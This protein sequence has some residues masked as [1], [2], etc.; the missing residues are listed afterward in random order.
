[1]IAVAYHHGYSDKV[2]LRLLRYFVA[3]AEELHFNRAAQRLY[4][5]QPS[6]SVQIRKLEQELGTPLFV[7]DR[8]RVAL[9]PAGVAL[10]EPARRVLAAADQL[11]GLA[12]AAAGAGGQLAIGFVPYARSRVLPNLMHAARHGMPAADLTV[13]AGNDTLEVFTDLRDGRI[14]AGIFGA[15]PDAAWLQTLTL[16]V[17]P[18]YAALPAGHRLANRSHLRLAELAAETFALFPRQLNPAAHDHLITW[19][20]QAGYTPIIGQASRRMDESLMFVAGGGGVALFPQSVT[21]AINEPKVVFRRLTH[22]TPT[23]EIVL[24]WDRHTLNPLVHQLT[25]LAGLS[26]PP[27]RPVRSSD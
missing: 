10:L 19:F 27:V 23:V 2:E 24:G 1:V 3:V 16:T 20:T 21:E 6:L 13:R 5:S 17:E 15:H 12:R 14:D 22:P 8:R 25:A 4:L 18:F 11:P 26:V 9:T 7:R